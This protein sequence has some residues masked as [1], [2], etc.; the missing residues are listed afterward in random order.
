[1]RLQYPMPAD[2][3]AIVGA[4]HAYADL[5][6]NYTH[7]YGGW[8]D[9]HKK[10]ERIMWGRIGQ[11]WV[12]M[13]CE[14]NRLPFTDDPSDY[15]EHDGYDIAVQNQRIDVKTWKASGVAYQVNAALAHHPVEW[16]CFLR[17][18]TNDV[19]NPRIIPQGCIPFADFWQ[20]STHV[21]CGQVIP[22][23]TYIQRYQNGSN[24]LCNVSVIIPF[25]RALLQMAGMT[26]PAQEPR[27]Q[28]IDTLAATAIPQRIQVS[29][30]EW[31]QRKARAQAFLKQDRKPGKTWA[32]LVYNYQD[33]D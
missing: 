33:D 27:N 25:E 16:Y 21:R 31:M 24:I 3:A 12:R 8:E 7:D 10:H 28:G 13:V 6:C 30:E 19:L 2:I 15:T 29:D 17:S 1:M 26:L 18:A 22:G 20:H 32:D 14:L 4:A 9:Q 23:T 5:S 11:G